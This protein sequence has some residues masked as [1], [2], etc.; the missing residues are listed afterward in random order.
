METR[1]ETT[2]AQGAAALASAGFDVSLLTEERTP[3][4]PADKVIDKR[5]CAFA[6][7]GETVQQMVATG[8]DDWTEVSIVRS[9]PLEG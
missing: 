7:I 1:Q 9:E 6:D 5:S 2:Q 8:G 4:G 3:G